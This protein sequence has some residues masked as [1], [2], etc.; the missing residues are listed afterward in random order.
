MSDS[1][2]PIATVPSGSAASAATL[3][4][5]AFASA[6][7]LTACGTTAG[8]SGGGSDVANESPD[9]GVAA[10]S[11]A[12]AA[13]GDVAGADAKDTAGAGDVTTGTD[14][15][16]IS[17][18]SD[19]AAGVDASD[20]WVADATDAAA[21][22]ADVASGPDS[23]DGVTA[24]CILIHATGN[25]LPAVLFGGMIQAAAGGEVKQFVLDTKGE[26]CA[27]TALDTEYFLSTN[28]LPS[29]TGGYLQY[30][31]Y[32]GHVQATCGANP[33]AC[34]VINLEFNNTGK[35]CKNLTECGDG[36]ACTDDNCG[37][38]GMCIHTSSPQK[39]TGATA[40]E[41]G[42]C[43]NGACKLSTPCDDQNG[44]TT[45]VCEA[46]NTC[47]HTITEGSAC[48]PYSYCHAGKCNA[49]GTCVDTGTY[50]DCDD[51]NF[52][53][54]DY[55]SPD[56]GGCVHDPAVFVGAP[57][58]V[59]SVSGKCST[60]G[61]CDVPKCSDGQKQEEETDVDCGGWCGSCADG[62]A[63]ALPVDC[64]SQVCV[65]N[66]C[67]APSCN[68]SVKNG[69]EWNVD[70]GGG[71]CPGC[72]TWAPCANNS[73]CA[74]GW[75][76]SGSFCQVPS[77]KDNAQNGTET[78][79]DCGGSCPG[80]QW[81][82]MKC[83]V[84]TDCASKSCINGACAAATCSDGLQNGSESSVDCGGIAS[85]SGCPVCGTGKTC[86]MDTDCA[87]K[88]CKG[89]TCVPAACNDGVQN[90]SETGVDCG[91]AVLAS[92]CTLCPDYQGC[93]FNTDCQSK[94]CGIYFACEAP[95]CNDGVA[96]GTETDKDCGG[97]CGPYCVQGANCNGNGDCTTQNCVAGICAAKL[98][99]GV[100]CSADVDCT[101][102]HC[103]DG[104]CCDDKCT[105][106]CWT[107]DGASNGGY[108]GVCA[109][110]QVGIADTMCKG[111]QVCNNNA[112]C[113]S[114][115][116][117]PCTSGAQC[118]YGNCYDGVC[119]DTIC[120]GTCTTCNAP[121]SVGIC[122][123]VPAGQD[124]HNDC[125]GALTCSGILGYCAP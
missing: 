97:L 96:N 56:K 30:P 93:L 102:G 95:T 6:G 124:P 67:A 33:K 65:G 41:V 23:A 122:D 46:G 87:D 70:C 15:A 116:G 34:L 80:C 115:L 2:C 5:V 125:P 57:C 99:N 32:S 53:T 52:C 7:I 45:D 83:K 119:C 60:L 90:G 25:G 55:C 18:A 100:V 1:R 101:T 107:C 47:T 106:E 77:C 84:D 8:G 68:D 113:S 54:N 37:I 66:L 13:G 36:N 20:A 92:G 75:C 88:A 24:T 109:G 42:M 11:D 43:T 28:A 59:D 74:S 16:G 104:V 112:V 117:S 121:G 105:D 40:C 4:L 108:P 71:N 26:Y 14:G 73:Q 63:C 27:D 79:V 10:G 9:N 38:F 85:G 58:F 110:M 39:C 51:A 48:T 91:G 94:V 64:S 62:K 44:C 49:G 50:L 19:V 61:A 78:D 103:V 3:W 35:Q 120:T 22:A 76:T 81:P 111:N 82:D 72:D 69:G 12:A 98:A 21:D 123:A 118:I 31:V 114:P 89:G 86:S 17:D 29:A